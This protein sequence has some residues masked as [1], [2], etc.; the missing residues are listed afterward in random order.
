MKLPP[1]YR[2]PLFPRKNTCNFHVFSVNT[3]HTRTQ[4][5]SIIKHN[6]NRNLHIYR[7]PWAISFRRSILLFYRP[8]IAIVIKIKSLFDRIRVDCCN[9]CI[10]VG[11]LCDQYDL[12]DQIAQ[13]KTMWKHLTREGTAHTKFQQ[14]MWHVALNWRGFEW[15]HFHERNSHEVESGVVARKR[16]KIRMQKKYSAGSV[17]DPNSVESKTIGW[18]SILMVIQ[19]VPYISHRTF[20]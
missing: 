14:N 15:C 12:L 6:L 5:T 19:C 13:N 11:S 8:I 10:F 17:A 20:L 9:I 4:S 3:F 1:F 2:I 18:P 7:W 16:K